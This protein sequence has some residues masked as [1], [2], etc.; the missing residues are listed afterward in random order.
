MNGKNFSILDLAPLYL[1]LPTLAI[2]FRLL[3]SI[4]KDPM[5]CFLQ[6]VFLS[7]LIPTALT[8]WN[9]WATREMT[10]EPRKK[11]NDFFVYLSLTILFFANGY[12][13][14]GRTISLVIITLICTRIDAKYDSKLLK[15]QSLF[16]AGI[17]FIYDVARNYDKDVF[18]KLVISYLGLLIPYWIFLHFNRNGLSLAGSEGKLRHVLISAVSFALLLWWG[19]DSI[20]FQ[21]LF[22]AVGSLVLLTV[23][24]TESRMQSPFQAFDRSAFLTNPKAHLLIL[25][26]ICMVV[27]FLSI[28]KHFLE[29]LCELSLNG[30][31]MI[32]LKP[33]SLEDTI[34]EANFNKSLHPKEP[35]S[36]TAKP[37]FISR[38]LKSQKSSSIFNFLLLNTSFMLVQL[39]YSFRSKSLSLLSDSLHMLLD[40]TSL[41]LGL[42]ANFLAA[43]DLE[44]QKASKALREERERKLKKRYGHLP[45]QEYEVKKAQLNSIQFYDSANLYPFGLARIETLAGFTNASLL[46]GIVF[47]IFSEGIHRIFHPVD[48]QKT[49]ELLI[50]SFLGLV[51]NLVGIYS[52][53]HGH[54][55]GHSHGHSHSQDHSHSHE[56]DN[57]HAHDHSHSKC[58][59]D[60]NEHKTPDHPQHTVTDNDNMRGIFLHILA[61]TLGSVGVVISTLLIKWLNIQILDPI[62]S[63]TIASLIFV[64]SLP[65][66]KSSSKNLLLSVTGNHDQAIKDFLSALSSIHAVKSY[67]TPRFWPLNG[68]GPKDTLTGYIHIQYY[69]TENSLSIKQ[70]V[71]ALLTNNPAFDKVY[72]QYENE[73]DD[74]WCRRTGIISSQ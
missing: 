27:S 23:S 7:S 67:S 24:Q 69:R 63:L 44:R 72:I 32:F 28:P 37:S 12:L 17:Y 31:V 40:C 73:I 3:G 10:D 19:L 13:P 22:I 50:V 64:S 45:R 15:F 6:S 18:P 60:H 4:Q 47:G 66:L 65:L 68:N 53:D 29:Y 2:S 30:F 38:L 9:N 56:N 42:L 74:C 16:F 48:L 25:N 11:G 46:L 34:D 41:L 14:V 61:D 70:K 51:V 59:D 49:N 20:N 5:L 1:A 39:L 33:L 36:S 55:P 52:F 26:L 21:M 58:E 43:E 54:S 57:T 62:M 35:R 71:Q 8:F